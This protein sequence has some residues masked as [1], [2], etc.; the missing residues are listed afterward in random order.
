MVETEIPWIIAGPGVRKDHEITNLTMQYDTAA[1]LAYLLHVK[2][3][4]C[5]L[6]RPVMSAFDQKR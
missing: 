5:W 2:P 4:L 6:G 1:T 3:S